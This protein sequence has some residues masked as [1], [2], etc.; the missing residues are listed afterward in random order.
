MS[1]GPRSAPI[2]ATSL[3]AVG[4]LVAMI[5]LVVVVAPGCDEPPGKITS[6]IT[7]RQGDGGVD[8]DAA[9][10]VAVDAP[11]DV[12]PVPGSTVLHVRIHDAAS[13]NAVP[14]KLFLRD[15]ATNVQ[16][17]F[18]NMVD[19]P[20]CMGMASSL[21][22]LGSGGALAT[23]N[24]V[25]VWNGEARIPIGT[26]WEVLG[27]GC[28]GDAA[29]QTRRQSIPFGHYLISAARGI[30]YEITTAEVDLSP[31]QGEVSIDLPIS[32]TVDT[33]GYFA[34]D[35]HIHSGSPDGMSG[36]G[37][38]DSMVSPQNRVK[39]E[40]VSGIEVVVSSDHD[41][42]TDLSVPIAQLWD[43][44]A[45]P[46][47]SIIGDEASANF[48]HFNAMPMTTDVAH[49]Y[50][51][52]ALAPSQVQ[53]MS[54]KQLFDSLHGLP[55][56]PLVQV[57]HPRLPYAAYFN[58]GRTC[59]WHDR[60]ALPKCS[61]DFEAIEVLNGWLACGG[62]V[63]ET[64]DDWYALMGFGV[65]LT[66]TGNSDTHGSSNIEAGF[67]RTYVRVAEDAVS[68]FDEGEFIDAVR[69]K[70]AIA[71]T[72]P[73]LTVRV[74][75]AG[76]GDLVTPTPGTKGQVDVSLRLQSA[77]W[78][79]VDV[80]RLLVD[81]VVVKTWN[82]PTTNGVSTSLFEIN[83]QKVTVSADAAITAEAEGGT[84][85]PSWMVGEFLL[86]PG[87]VQICGNPTQPGMIPF[88]T[89][90]PVFVDF[91]GDGK[92][93]AQMNAA[94]AAAVQDS[95]VPPQNGPHDCNPLS[96][97]VPPPAPTGQPATNNR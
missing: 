41:Y 50:T 87:M 72:G 30:E 22:E 85:L 9:D 40:A 88:A 18:G 21:R 6:S 15:A 67:P 57:N 14:A 47:A 61:L 17:H 3:L 66:A 36:K 35:M 37:S 79:K 71:T 16:L 86:S 52:G 89:T 68:A 82:V 49:P 80:V 29:T 94:R 69:N 12:P 77:S 42:L 97:L 44:S 26:D 7:S 10:A 5:A 64:L 93:R 8:A 83:D 28:T 27:N 56:N 23:W 51:N 92:F 60:S 31:D 62:K 84:P 74:G 96:E 2:R 59:D 46:M 24:G 11:P 19:Q 25:A 91:D 39:T 48:G 55:T 20:L 78:I 81:G 45:P 13:G 32:R 43:A 73:F 4:A 53:L 63:H 76:E 34:A 90:N 38:W 75:T 70:H 65:A 54:P 95:W 1:Q 58:D 33:R